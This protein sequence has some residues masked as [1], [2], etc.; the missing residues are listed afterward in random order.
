MTMTVLTEGEA[1]VDK[2]APSD[3]AD[4]ASQRVRVPFLS[5]TGCVRGATC[6]AV[7]SRFACL[8]S[9][10]TVYD[11]FE[12]AAVLVCQ[13]G[14]LLSCSVNEHAVPSDFGFPDIA[15]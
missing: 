15:V 10:G 1:G 11:C 7:A 5:L 6:T 3:G 8:S 13:G 4:L 12:S 9:A 2:Q 14:A